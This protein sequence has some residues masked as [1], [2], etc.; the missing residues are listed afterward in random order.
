MANEKKPEEEQM[1]PVLPKYQE[2][3]KDEKF[4]VYD[5][6]KDGTFNLNTSNTPT[7]DRN[8]KLDSLV[9]EK[10]ADLT[11]QGVTGA[12]T[13]I[14]E[15]LA[16]EAMD[17][18]NAYQALNEQ[19]SKISQA[20]SLIGATTHDAA[21]TRDYSHLVNEISGNDH[22][23]A[24]MGFS[25][26]AQNKLEEYEKYLSKSPSGDTGFRVATFNDKDGTYEV[27]W[28]SKS[29][30]TSNPSA[31]KN[32]V[33]VNG[34][35]GNCDHLTGKKDAFNLQWNTSKFSASEMF[36]MNY[37]GLKAA[38]DKEAKNA[39]LLTATTFSNQEA[40][41]RLCELGNQ[42][43]TYLAGIN[44]AGYDKLSTNPAK[45]ESELAGYIKSLQKNP[46]MNKDVIDAAKME[47]AGLKAGRENL[48]RKTLTGGAFD[49]GVMALNLASGGQ[50]GVMKGLSFTTSS[51][52]GVRKVIRGSVNLH[53]NH[54]RSGGGIAAK[55]VHRGAKRL[56]KNVVVKHFTRGGDTL[57]DKFTKNFI[58]KRVE[59]ARKLDR[60]EA[61]KKER[62]TGKYKI[63]EIKYKDKADKFAK[64][65]SKLAGKREKL[66]GST[67]K[68]NGLR[69]SVLERR[70]NYIEK[71]S[72]KLDGRRNKNSLKL[73]KREMFRARVRNSRA[74]RI[75]GK[76]G[77]VLKAPGAVVR[78]ITGIVDAI[79]KKIKFVF[80][81]I[82]IAVVGFTMG[83]CAF[84]LLVL[85]LVANFLDS[86]PDSIFGTQDI[87]YNQYI[88]DKTCWVLGNGY[89]KVAARDAYWHYVL[90]GD[91]KNYSL[92]RREGHEG[93]F[94]YYWFN[95]LEVADKKNESPFYEIY[96]RE[97]ADNTTQGTTKNFKYERTEDGEKFDDPYAEENQGKEL[98]DGQ[99]KFGDTFKKKTMY[100]GNTVIKGVSGVHSAINGERETLDSINVNI[101]PILSMAHYRFSGEI[102]YNNYL[103]VLGY[104]YTMWVRSHDISK[105]D[106]YANENCYGKKHKGY[107]LEIIDPCK[108]IFADET[109]TIAWNKSKTYDQITRYKTQCSNV[110]I[111]GYNA[112]LGTT[113]GVVKAAV[114]DFCEDV[115]GVCRDFYGWLTKK[116][117]SSTLPVGCELYYKGQFSGVTDGYADNGKVDI[118]S[119]GDDKMDDSD[120]EDRN[121]DE[122]DENMKETLYSGDGQDVSKVD[123][124]KQYFKLKTSPLHVYGDI[125]KKG[126]TVYETGSA[127]LVYDTD[128]FNNI[129]AN[130]DGS[131]KLVNGCDQITYMQFSSKEDT[132]VKNQHF[133]WP[134]SDDNKLEGKGKAGTWCATTCGKHQHKHGPNC[135]S[136][137]TMQA[138]FSDGDPHPHIVP[139][140]H[141]HGDGTCN[142]DA[143]PYGGEEHEH[144]PWVDENNPGCWMTVAICKGHCGG[145]AIGKMDIVVTNSWEGLMM[146]DDLKVPQ[147]MIS[148]DFNGWIDCSQMTWTLNSWRTY[149]I[150]KTDSWYSKS[151]NFSPGRI[152]AWGFEKAPA[153]IDKAVEGLKKT[154][155]SI[156]NGDFWKQVKDFFE[157]GAA[158]KMADAISRQK[159]ADMEDGDDLWEFTSW[160]DET[161]MYIRPELA[162]GI[163][164]NYGNDQYGSLTDDLQQAPGYSGYDPATPEQSGNWEAAIGEWSGSMLWQVYF[165]FESNYPYPEGNH[166]IFFYQ[167]DDGVLK[168]KTKTDDGEEIDSNKVTL[169]DEVVDTPIEGINRNAKG[170]TREEGYDAGAGA[171][172]D[173]KY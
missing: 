55:V 165:P 1:S 18:D 40:K 112:A 104:S 30:Y 87:N 80:I 127:F 171:N 144:S 51:V 10:G 135:C 154:V 70:Q 13:R 42:A 12:A 107:R 109:K 149:W 118:D 57:A 111:H 11:K 38:A 123:R 117:P 110:Y 99:L 37:Q 4:K 124:F 157:G 156:V 39:S 50:S 8:D 72:K 90:K 26:A 25:N 121:P 71:R 3:E 83:M 131:P 151:R 128:E 146:L 142:T 33:V 53:R 65:S 160:Y 6:S 24:E 161:G 66:A 162:E 93:Q 73:K 22:L 49:K 120:Y 19:R 43:S 68:V 84:A 23:L 54:L 155:I 126:A 27:K 64:K 114:D 20:M 94:Q 172:G 58:D 79:M 153:I 89:T 76:V 130:S 21:I 77:N 28:A 173:Y 62:L 136:K 34:V 138:V 100:G 16:K 5:P 86:M 67:S 17:E 164:M 88:V 96:A 139:T 91:Y 105:Y 150:N 143:C 15:D 48:S 141:T 170:G 119:L 108:K 63:R 41:N 158:K 97:Q 85:M 148:A 134:L 9:G 32:A 75:A 56:D 92:D 152:I 106:S 140:G 125:D 36:G 82:P 168:Y 103:T 46:K 81:T 102:N 169:K 31:Y 113:M 14:A 132:V 147:M 59:K 47:L 35:N 159:S 145:H 116:T 137:D 129:R 98:L 78:W 7:Y 101:V 45:R 74:G 61:L 163:I 52:A 2:E 133:P 60:I 166:S 95:Q 115:A 29:E 167:T 44:I 122:L 69:T